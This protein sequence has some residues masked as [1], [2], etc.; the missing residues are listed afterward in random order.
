VL[1]IDA[2]KC[3]LP[4]RLSC[5]LYGFSHP[6][7]VSGR[8]HASHFSVAQALQYCLSIKSLELAL[9]TDLTHEL[10]HWEL[11]RQLEVWQK[12]MGNAAHMIGA[13]ENQNNSREPW[14]RGLWDEDACERYGVLELLTSLPPQAGT[15]FPVFRVA[16]DRQLIGFKPR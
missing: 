6:S 13:R 5:R 11:D 7:S 15:K 10:E 12:G 1:V 16:Y 9:L 2:L 4:L 3:E 8:R 14:W